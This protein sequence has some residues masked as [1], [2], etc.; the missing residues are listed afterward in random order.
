MFKEF[1]VLFLLLILTVAALRFCYQ[2][3]R[4]FFCQ[5]TT[6][7]LYA[8]ILINVGYNLVFIYPDF[9]YEGVPIGDSEENLFVYKKDS[10][11]RWQILNTISH[12]RDVFLDEEGA[13]F[14]HYFELFAESTQRIEVGNTVR[15]ALKDSVDFECYGELDM[16]ELL[17]YA[18]PDRQGGRKPNLYLQKESLRGEKE[19]VGIMVEAEEQMDLY[20][21]SKVYYESLT[22]LEG[23]T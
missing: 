8:A 20:V 6:G 12:N 22:K 10:Q 21:M 18:F 5:I 15:N 11:F 14:A 2:R 9:V 13:L 1:G 3:R 4:V 23:D 7:L 17:D 16:V 19:M